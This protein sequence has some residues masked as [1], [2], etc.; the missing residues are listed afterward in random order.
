MTDSNIDDKPF[1]VQ[2]GIRYNRRDGGVSG[3]LV[4]C[5]AYLRNDLLKDESNGH[6]YFPSGNSIIGSGINKKDI[7]LISE[8]KEP[9]AEPQDDFI[10]TETI[11]SKE[12][13]DKFADAVA[14]WGPW[15]GWNGGEC[16]VDG[17]VQPHFRNQ[18]RMESE[19]NR[20][21]FAPKMP[22]N[23]VHEDNNSDII[24]YRIKKEPVVTTDYIYIDKDGG[25]FE[26][27][28]GDG[29]RKAIITLTDGE[30]SIRWAE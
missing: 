14:E 22:S 17:E 5:D 11:L 19:K 23:W 20:V 1:T 25:A 30:P 16:P 24:A 27:D 6:Q 7:D 29:D 26:I 10:Q 18:N 8:Y 13:F 21:L 9:T 12:A 4:T 2:A 28:Y 3:V 15:I